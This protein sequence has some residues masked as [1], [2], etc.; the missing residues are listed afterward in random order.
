MSKSMQ[1]ILIVTILL[2]QLGFSQEMT[3][4]NPVI[5]GFNP[6][7]S[8]V[9]VGEDYHYDLFLTERDGRK[10]LVARRK[11]DDISLE[12]K[13]VPVNAET[14]TL[15]VSG[16]PWKYT[17]S[18]KKDDEYQELVTMKNWFITI[19]TVGEYYTGFTGMFLGLFAVGEDTE[20]EFDRF[21]YCEIP[22]D[23]KRFRIAK[24]WKEIK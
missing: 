16:D 23:M 9:R 15:K 22:S 6:D 2:S 7:P 19:H 18:Y 11:I 20:A 17:F 4:E 24:F 5:S 3:Y 14:V 8:V 10:V 21:S 13:V 12:E 1:L